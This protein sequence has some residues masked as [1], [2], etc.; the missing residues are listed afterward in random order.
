MAVDSRLFSGLGVFAAVLEAGN[1]VRA[2]EALGLTQSAVSRSV[3]R[4]EER[5]GVR[6]LERTS[7]TIRLTED[8]ERFCAEALPLFSQLG[9]VAEG[10]V[11]AAG[12]ARGR[13]RINVESSF[14]RLFLAPRLGAFLKAYPEVRLELLVRE[15]LGDLVAEGIDPAILFGEPVPSALIARRLLQVHILTCASPDYL[16]RC[17]R[18]R[19]PADLEAEQHECLLFRDPATGKP[20]PW[21]F[22]RGRKRLGVNVTGRVMVNDA[23]TYVAL[24]VAGNGIAQLIDL[25]IEPLLKNGKLINLFPEW[26]DE[27]FPLYVYYLS[28]HSVPAKLRVF[29]DFLVSSLE[30]ERPRLFA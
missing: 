1:F 14:A 7:K 19:K 29:L 23:L 11:K 13:L 8:G 12:K 18:P 3:Q 24:C 10:M 15:R 16:A 26:T 28:R 6:L 9:E 17:G 22:H 30:A 27:L 25:T 5:L 20:F 4:L 21:E 2:G